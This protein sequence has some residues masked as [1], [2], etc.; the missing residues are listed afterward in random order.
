MQ[1]FTGNNWKECSNGLIRGPG[2]IENT[3]CSCNLFRL[4]GLYGMGKSCQEQFVISRKHMSRFERPLLLSIDFTTEHVDV[5]LNYFKNLTAGVP[6][7]LVLCPL[8]LS[9]C[10]K[11]LGSVIRLMAFLHYLVLLF[12]P[13]HHKSGRRFQTSFWELFLDKK[14]IIWNSTSKTTTNKTKHYG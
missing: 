2:E 14:T 12:L 13:L 6:Q 7:M 3:P 8:Y 5:Q 11:Y 1:A 4:Q 10:T 9:L